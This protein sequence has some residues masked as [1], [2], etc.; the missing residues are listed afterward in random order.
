M[1]ISTIAPINETTSTTITIEEMMILLRLVD[2]FAKQCTKRLVEHREIGLSRRTAFGVALA[3]LLLF[4]SVLVLEVKLPEAKAALYSDDFANI[5]N[6]TG[7][8]GVWT[9]IDGVLQ[10]TSAV[11]GGKLNLGR[12]HSLD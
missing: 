7:V 1:L 8:N 5:S 10:G 9:S 3:F 11:G 4:S 12:R 6:W 2:V